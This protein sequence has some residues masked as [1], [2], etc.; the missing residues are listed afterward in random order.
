MSV[1]TPVGVRPLAGMRANI[2]RAYTFLE[3]HSSKLVGF[4]EEAFLL[5]VPLQMISSNSR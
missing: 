3:M 2:P 1:L 4:E 5:A